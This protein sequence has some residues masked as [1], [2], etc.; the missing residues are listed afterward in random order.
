MILVPV[1]TMSIFSGDVT[2]FIL[3][4]IDPYLYTNRHGVMPEDLS[5]LTVFFFSD[6]CLLD[7]I[8]FLIFPEGETI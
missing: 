6:H 2:P 7:Y 8:F 1:M 5:L 4:N 3:V